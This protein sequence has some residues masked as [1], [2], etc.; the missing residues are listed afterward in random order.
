MLRMDDQAA[1]M[2]R[3]YLLVMPHRHWRDD[4]LEGD[5]IPRMLSDAIWTRRPDRLASIWISNQPKLEGSVDE[6]LLNGGFP[7]LQDLV[8]TR[9]PLVTGNVP[10]AIGKCSVLRSLNL[11][12]C[13]YSGK[14]PHEL[15][16]CQELQKVLLQSNKFT[17][18]FKMG[19]RRLRNAPF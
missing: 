12:D 13:L 11:S 10:A 15:G 16:N 19:L 17:G 1:R 8:V 14:I 9:C 6:L 4:M 2:P 7:L 3:G 5:A 18:A